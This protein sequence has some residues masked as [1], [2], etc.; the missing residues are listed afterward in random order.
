MFSFNIPMH[1]IQS[2][3]RSLPDPLQLFSLRGTR[4]TSRG[5]HVQSREYGPLSVGHR[6]FLVS[7]KTAATSMRAYTRLSV[8]QS[9]P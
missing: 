4:V 1:S 3:A 2:N 7:G 9:S 5:H 6:L 8:P